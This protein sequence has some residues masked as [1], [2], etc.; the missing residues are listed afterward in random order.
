MTLTELPRWSV[1]DVHESLDARSFT[2]ALELARSDADRLVALFDELDIRATDTR[3]VTADD[4]TAADR[5]LRELNRV[6]DAVNLLRVYVYATVATDCA[7][8]VR[9]PCSARPVS[10]TQHCGR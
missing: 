8:N 9:S 5:A 3:P 6:T 7:T 10:S 1:A 4:A 2:D